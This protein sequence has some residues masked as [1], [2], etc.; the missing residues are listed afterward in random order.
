MQALAYELGVS[1]P[2]FRRVFRQSTGLPPRQYL[3][4][5]KINMAKQLMEDQGL[6]LSAVARKAGFEDP[7][8]FSRLF[9]Q[10]TGISPSLWRR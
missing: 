4:N 3:L 10:K 8:Y 7:Y 5:L 6:K 9:K 1:Y 2:H